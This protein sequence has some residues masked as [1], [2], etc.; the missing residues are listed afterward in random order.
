MLINETLRREIGREA[1]RYCRRCPAL[2]QKDGGEYTTYL[3]R[4]SQCRLWAFLRLLGLRPG[5]DFDAPTAEET[6]LAEH[7]REVRR[8]RGVLPILRLNHDWEADARFHNLVSEAARRETPGQ[9]VWE[10]A[11]WRF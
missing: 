6:R 8:F 11:P 5:A 3:C 9:K 1:V 2:E 7:A 4:N 10:K